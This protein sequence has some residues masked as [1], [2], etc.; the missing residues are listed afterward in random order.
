MRPL[1]AF[2]AQLGKLQ[3]LAQP[4]FLPLEDTNAWQFLLLLLALLGVVTGLTLFLISGAVAATAAGA[5]QFQQ[6][7][8]PGVAQQ[9][10]GLWLQPSLSIGVLL[11][12]ACVV[13]A[14]IAGSLGLFEDEAPPR[15]GN[16]RQLQRTLAL[17]PFALALL[18]GLAVV[19]SILGALAV[20]LHGWVGGWNPA[21]Q[22]GLPLPVRTALEAGIPR[23][24]SVLWGG[25]I[26]SRRV[27]WDSGPSSSVSPRS[28]FSAPG[29]SG[30]AG[31]PGACW[32]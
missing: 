29:S 17:V 7:F 23:A 27:W 5:P 16:R 6:R 20:A 30:G 14:V 31:C 4:Y 8:L 25:C 19:L 11:V 2:C 15:P 9:V 32:G 18:S 26:A 28:S 12:M 24:L 1:K 13:L 21:L 3:R 22:A 10:S